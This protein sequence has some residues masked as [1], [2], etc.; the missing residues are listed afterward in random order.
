M[1]SFC[2]YLTLVSELKIAERE[3]VRWPDVPSHY[4]NRNKIRNKIE[5]DR[6]LRDGKRAKKN[7]FI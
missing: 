5:T 4:I 3:R 7:Y 1:Q 6:L 2:F